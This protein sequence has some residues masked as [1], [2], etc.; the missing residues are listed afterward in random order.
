MTIGRDTT[1]MPG[2]LL[3]GG[4]AIGAGC[5]LEAH[6]VIRS[7]VVRDGAHIREFCHLEQADVGPRA[8]AGP[9]AR[10]RPGSVIGEEEL[11]F[12]RIPQR[13]VPGGGRAKRDRAKP[14]K[15]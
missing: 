5:L 3:L 6:S 9:F 14:G 10:M 1:V 12:A 7:S 8:I 15:G 4:T 13:V 2:C 11:A